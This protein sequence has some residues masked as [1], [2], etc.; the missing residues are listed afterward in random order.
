MKPRMASA[1]L[2]LATLPLVGQA[3]DQTVLGKA[4][5]VKDPGTVTKRKIV[6]KAVEPGTDDT[7]VGDPATNGATLTVRADGASPSEQTWTLPV[8][9][10]AKGK[11]FWSGDAVKGFK[12]V[13]SQ[14]E[15]GP[16]KVAQVKRTKAGVFK[17]KMIV[18]G[19]LGTIDVLPPDAGTAGCALLELGGGD[20][21]SVRFADGNVA[22]NANKVF[23]VSNPGTEGTCVLCGNGVVDPGEQCDGSACGAF[24]GA[25][26]ADC[27]CT[28]DF[29]DGS[30]CLF[31]FPSDF[32]T[33]E[34]PATDTGRRVNFS[35][36]AMPQNEA[37]VSMDPAPYHGND[38]FSQG[39][40]IL[41]HVPNVDLGV[42]GAAPITDIER[43]LD[44]DAP[45]VVV[46]AATLEHHLLWVELDANA[47]TEPDTALIIRP[48]VNFDEGTRYVVALRNMKD[49]GGAIIPPGATFQAYRD[50]TPTGDPALEARRAHMEE[51]FT[52]LAAAGVARND[53]YLAW[54]FTV[55]S[56]RNVTERL[57][58]MRDDAFARLGSDAPTFAITRITLSA[59]PVNAPNAVNGAW[60]FSSLR[61]IFS[62][63]G[64]RS[65][66]QASVLDPIG[67]YMQPSCK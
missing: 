33:V 23:K 14:G 56:T 62:I 35:L 46:N 1:V 40:S 22:N 65:V 6:V 10:S 44:A 4:F 20:S 63:D 2:L 41:L 37:G 25:C 24:G 42:T 59:M 43:S 57:L 52:T 5:V 64:S 12:Y 26:Q 7:V 19:K 58:F 9:T 51:I 54:D 53:L 30:E 31:P 18:L 45:V 17:M 8:G 28:C 67:P 49:A 3:A 60:A 48:A 55:A 36:D 39:T 66:S 11:P 21:Y 61:I 47:T 27:T 13:D 38:G 16:V 29:L 32:L 34:D 50:D 15:N